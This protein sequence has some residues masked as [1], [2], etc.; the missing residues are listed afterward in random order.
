MKTL[1]FVFKMLLLIIIAGCNSPG[2]I[3]TD[4]Q[5]LQCLVDSLVLSYD[6]PGLSIAV[7]LPSGKTEQFVSGFADK[8]SG[9]RL[10][11]SHFFLS[12]SIGKTYAA[13][14]LFQFVANG[15]VDLNNKY[16]DYFPDTTW[17]ENIPN[18][19]EI[20]IGMLLRHTSG[21]PRYEFKAGVWQN[22]AQNPDKIWS[23]ADRLSFIFEDSALHK[24]GE[25]WS[26]SD[27]NYILLGMLI[28]EITGNHY[29]YEVETRLLAPLRL[30]GTSPALSRSIDN[31]P[32]GYSRLPAGFRMPPRVVSDGKYV[33]NPQ[34]EWSGGGMIST[35]S[36][37]ARWCKS[38]YEGKAFPDSLLK[39]VLDTCDPGKLVLPGTSY[40]TGSFIFHTRHGDAYGHTGFM[41][42]FNAVMAYYSEYR[43]VVAMNTNC[44]YAGSEIPIQQFLDLV[45][46]LIIK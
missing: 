13:A 16:A 7:T 5:A 14:I 45:I 41:P 26:Y 2:R 11:K 36:D 3:K 38:F 44:D 32:Q 10:E 40:G 21:L 35:T 39:I 12:G 37:M 25:G 20:T 46:D 34:M 43:I 4:R 18:I 29:Y 42:G 9:T 22:L 33:F 24:A 17:L 28:E 31:L 6:L 30:K 8:E 1:E 27:S 23:Y 19:N 15:D